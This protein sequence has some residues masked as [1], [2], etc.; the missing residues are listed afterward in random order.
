MASIQK[1]GKKYCVIYNYRDEDGKKKQKWETWN[2]LNEANKRKKEIEYKQDI[3]DFVIPKCTTIE[4]LMDEYVSLYGKE[5]WALSTFERNTRM[6][7]NYILPK[8]GN[9][10]LEDINTRFLELFYKELQTSKAAENIYNKEKGGGFIK[11]SVIRDIHKLLRSCFKQAVKWELMEKNPADY[12]T[13]PKYES[14]ESRSGGPNAR[15]YTWLTKPATLSFIEQSLQHKVRLTEWPALQESADKNALVGQ[16]PRGS[17]AGIPFVYDTAWVYINLN[18]PEKY[19][20]AFTEC[21]PHDVNLGFTTGSSIRSP[22]DT[23]AICH[24][25]KDYALGSWATMSTWNQR[26]NLLGFWGGDRRE[27][28]LLSDRIAA[29]VR[30]HR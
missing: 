12:A 8:I 15:S 11:P 26:R 19:R 17:F 23:I 2:T 10:K 21:T 9:K 7:Q 16:S 14:R 22:F 30:S 18:C 13:V 27:K 1:R 4:E 28:L 20:A 6:I 29:K 5:K 25:E 24:M 3:G